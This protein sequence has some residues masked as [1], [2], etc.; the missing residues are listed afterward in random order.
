M[1]RK[2]PIQVLKYTLIKNGFFSAIKVAYKILRSKIWKKTRLVFTFT[3]TSET[4]NLNKPYKENYMIENHE[5]SDITNLNLKSNLLSHQE[6]LWDIHEIF[7]I[8]GRIW[9]GKLNG[10]STNFGLSRSAEDLDNY[11]LQL[12]NGS[13]YFSN[14]ITFNKFRGQGLYRM[15]LTNMLDTLTQEGFNHF[16]VDCVDW[17][18]PSIYGI[19]RAGF[20]FVGVFWKNRV[21][22]QFA[23]KNLN[24]IEKEKLYIVS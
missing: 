3:A 10:E 8:K 20:K 7:R 21:M 19:Q 18:I 4:S 1:M 17:N 5:A 24:S 23:A 14:F 13:I 11:Y 22:R 9:V 6:A 16:Y 15:L 2:Y 12:P